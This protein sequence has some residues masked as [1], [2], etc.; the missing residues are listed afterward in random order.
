MWSRQP[1]IVKNGPF[2]GAF[3]SMKGVFA[4]GFDPVKIAFAGCFDA[5]A[6]CV[7]GLPLE[8]ADIDALRTRACNIIRYGCGWHAVCIRR[9]SLLVT[10]RAVAK[11][12]FPP[13]AQNE[14]S[15]SVHAPEGEEGEEEGVRARS[16]CLLCSA[17][18][19]HPLILRRLSRARLLTG[20]DTW[21]V[22]LQPS[23]LPLFVVHRAFAGP[24]PSYAEATDENSQF[25]RLGMQSAMYL[26]NA[27]NNRVSPRLW[28]LCAFA[29]F[30]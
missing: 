12:P 26:R 11:L 22:P 28:R 29:L 24:L 5:S 30:L 7:G 10:Y 2:A 4:G 16:N 15:A 20:G 21:S 13:Q 23:Q 25:R 9:R 19:S 3:D 6:R 8:G 1:S 14:L 27:Q 18:R 17:S